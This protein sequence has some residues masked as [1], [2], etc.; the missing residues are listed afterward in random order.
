MDPLFFRMKMKAS[1]IRNHPVD[2][3]RLISLRRFPFY[4][5]YA[6]PL[7]INLNA[8]P[9]FITTTEDALEITGTTFGLPWTGAKHKQ[10]LNDR[11]K[12]C[13]DFLS[14]PE[15][16]QLSYDKQYCF[17]LC[18]WKNLADSIQALLGV[19]SSCVAASLVIFLLS[20]FFG[21]LLMD[22]WFS[23]SLKKADL[24]SSLGFTP[25]ISRN[26]LEQ[27]TFSTRLLPGFFYAVTL[28]GSFTFIMIPVYLILE[29]CATAS[30]FTT[31]VLILVSCILLS[32]S[33]IFSVA[34]ALIVFFIPFAGFFAYS[35]VWGRRNYHSEFT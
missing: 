25:V 33:Y 3:P 1:Y 24:L 19:F 26:F 16:I 30:R 4:R 17:R 34:S 32:Y 6:D 31:A 5:Y 9:C 12:Q 21:Y 23:Q 29:F 35:F 15:C 22:H 2:A 7:S 28:G 18:S 14:A 13:N 10:A 11:L 27:Q 8:I 20:W